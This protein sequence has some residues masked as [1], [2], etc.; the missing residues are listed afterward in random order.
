M[1]GENKPRILFYSCFSNTHKS[2]SQIDDFLVSAGLC[3]RVKGWIYDPIFFLDHAPHSL[4]CLDPELVRDPPKWRTK[5]QWLRDSDLISLLEEQIHVYF[6]ACIRWKAF[7]GARLVAL[8]ALNQR[9]L[10]RC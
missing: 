8:Q 5:Q 1:Y 9:K 10:N 6:S 3:S 2:Y 7:I 4:S